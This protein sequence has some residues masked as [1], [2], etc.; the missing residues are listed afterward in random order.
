MTGT[1]VSFRN[2]FS[3]GGSEGGVSDV[4]PPDGE[5]W[6]RA[7]GGDRD[8]FAVLF[9]RHARA[10]YNHCFRLTASWAAADD[11]TSAVFLVAWRKRGRADLHG[12]SLRPWLLGVATNEARTARRSTRRR[13]ELLDRV[14]AARDTADHA[15]EVAG[16]VDDEK[17]MADLLAEVARLPRA[18]REVLALVAWSGLS[19]AD[20]ATALGIAEVSVR[21]RMSRARARLRGALQLEESR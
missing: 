3:A 11:L 15:D 1:L 16:R 7:A 4:E 9:D 17:R 6:A 13:L 20:A 5:L 10:V 14:P 18:E 2:T 8:A 12:G 19:Y 21:S